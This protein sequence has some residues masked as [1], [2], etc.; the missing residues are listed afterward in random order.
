MKKPI[1]FQNFPLTSREGLVQRHSTNLFQ[2]LNLFFFIPD[3]KIRCIKIF[4]RNL[5]RESMLSWKINQEN[6]K[7]LIKTVRVAL[8]QVSPF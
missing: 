5:F 6:I 3:L 7:I 4:I 8:C 1:I 2:N